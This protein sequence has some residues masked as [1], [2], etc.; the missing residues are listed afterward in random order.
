[1]YTRSETA[2]A[3]VF[4]GAFAVNAGTTTT[5]S[6]SLIPQ[7]SAGMLVS[8][9]GKI[10]NRST[11]T[12]FT[13][14]NQYFIEGNM[15]TIP[16]QITGGRAG[17]TV[18]NS[19]GREVLDSNVVVVSGQTE[20]LVQSVASADDVKRA[21]VLVNGEEIY[22]VTTTSSYGYILD[23][24]SSGN[25]RAC[26]KVYNLSPG[27]NTIEA[28][29]FATKLEYFNR[30]HEEIFV[31]PGSQSTFTLS[32]PP[33]NIEPVVAATIVEAGNPS[34]STDRRRLLPPN[35]TYYQVANGQTTYAID[36]ENNRPPGYYSL[37]D[38]RIYVN[39]GSVP[40]R[41]GFDYVVN[42][43]NSIT[44]ATNLLSDGDAMAIMTLKD[45]EYFVSGNVLTLTSPLVNGSLRVLTFT[46][47]DSLLMH[48][49]KFDANN[50]NRYTL[51]R[52]A[53]N[54][55]YV[56]V[57][58]NGLP[59]IPRYDFEILE[60]FVTI[61]FSE[62]IDSKVGDKVI[63]TTVA[64]PAFETQLLGYRIFKDI[65]DR[66]EYKRLAEY[67]TTFLTRDLKLGDTEIYVQ[68]DNKLIPPNPAQNKPGVI[69]VDGERIEFFKKEGNVLSQL[70][71][72]T[73]GTGPAFYSQPGTSVIDL[74]IQ[75]TIPYVES[76]FIQRLLTTNSTTYAISTITSTSTGDGIV[77]TP[78]IRAADQ[79]TVYYGGRQ[80]RKNAVSIHD[81]NLAY[82]TTNDSL[83]VV[84]P[85]FTINTATQL[86]T[87]NISESITTG[88]QITIVQK[89]G[90]VWT[91]SESLLMSSVPQAE[92]I[93]RKQAK[94]PDVYYY[95]GDP[96]LLYDSYFPLTNENDDP[97]E[98][99]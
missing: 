26:V 53:Y 3:L 25:N 95:G 28:W 35:V 51:T 96:T 34:T 72:S 24:V 16:P 32:I 64:E 56:W 7:A 62:F 36:N 55:N 70:R 61:Q 17:Y 73:L 99:Y 27:T 66:Y 18:I 29:F 90:Y 41:P 14:S 33:A 81:I 20:A 40:L 75:Q 5:A 19:G 8:F 83:N 48:T 98:E 43:D 67:H 45:Y 86:L 37:G 22:E 88:T 69:L 39:G 92:F 58:L 78:G 79:L 47:H 87:L 46:N 31:V 71:R 50:L 97:L 54:D 65:L 15:I 10:F 30:V 4:T 63:I 38:I 60:D 80:L 93:R 23:N 21:Y 9:N 2:R 6:L 57:Y 82:D 11:T 13:T 91:G 12:N 77:I 85:E 94:L 42:G 76:T 49:E 84:A 52:P 68:N 74:S 89:K 44:L 59:L 1:V